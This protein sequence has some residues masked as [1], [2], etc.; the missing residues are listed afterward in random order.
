MEIKIYYLGEREINF[1]E[2]PKTR[3]PLESTKAF[4][5]ARELILHSERFF[6]L[7][8]FLFFGLMLTIDYYPLTFCFMRFWNWKGKRNFH[9]IVVS[10]VSADSGKHH[11]RTCPSFPKL[12][13]C[14]WWPSLFRGSSGCAKC[15]H[16]FNT[17]K[18]I[19]LDEKRNFLK[20]K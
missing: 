17:S 5:N 12:S 20:D 10:I 16:V 6:P 9:E 11:T 4:S 18:C 13:H 7:S 2:K 8:F 14:L 1:L 3:I 19:G 15:F